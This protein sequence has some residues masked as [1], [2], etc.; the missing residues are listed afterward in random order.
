MTT[1]HGRVRLVAGLD[2]LGW[3]ELRGVAFALAGLVGS[4]IGAAVGAAVVGAWS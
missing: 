1:V 2:L 4:L 3:D